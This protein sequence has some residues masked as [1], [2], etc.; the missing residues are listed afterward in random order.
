[1]TIT[2]GEFG[3]AGIYRGTLTQNGG[4]LAFGTPTGILTIDGDLDLADVGELLFQLNGTLAGAEY[5]QLRIIGVGRAVA[6]DNVNIIVATGFEVQVGHSFTIIE[7]DDPT[8]IITG[9]LNNEEG[10]ALPPGTHTTTKATF[11]RSII[12][13]VTETMLFFP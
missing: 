7:L 11:T 9:Q 13:E 12:R 5:D 3:G 2:A 6:L 8:S 1:M 4:V 10:E